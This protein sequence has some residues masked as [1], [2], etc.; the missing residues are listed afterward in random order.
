[1]RPAKSFRWLLK[2]HLAKESFIE[3]IRELPKNFV[4]VTD[5]IF[6]ASYNSNKFTTEAQRRR[7]I[8]EALTLNFYSIS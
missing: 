5:I 4:K 3:K 8:F 1:M 7:N 2:C 6:L